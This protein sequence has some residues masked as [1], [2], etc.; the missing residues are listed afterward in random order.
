[1]FA[2]WLPLI[3]SGNHAPADPPV[4]YHLT[5]TTSIEQDLTSQ[6][7]GKVDGALKANA[8]ITVAVTDSADGQSVR[9]TLDSIALDPSGFIAQQLQQRPNAASE[10]RGGTVH[11]FV[12]R[13]R[14]KSAMQVSD[15]TNPI[16]S[17]V[18][19]AASVLY[20]AVRRTAKVGDT[21]ADTNRITAPQGSNGRSG[22]VI[23][24]WR[25]VGT[26]GRALVLDG[27]SRTQSHA[28]NAS[29]QSL[30]VNGH[31]SE[32]IVLPAVGP[33]RRA[34]VQ[35]ASDVSMSAP[36]IQ[37]VPEHTTGTLEIEQIH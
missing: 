27:S 19:Q 35:T 37:P 12:S 2:I 36:N 28:E 7:H 10:A 21:W 6:G 4:R 13:G 17:V 16:F 24:T 31:S 3:L 33:V 8:V 32:H 26:E 22:Q 34:S 11:F 1:M 15:S 9:I 5:V 23:D 14:I 29:G 18:A 25:A 30:T 20:P